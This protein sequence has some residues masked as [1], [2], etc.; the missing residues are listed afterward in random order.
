[1]KKRTLIEIIDSQ[2]FL[3]ELTD[4]IRTVVQEECDCKEGSVEATLLTSKEVL[5]KLKISAPTL[6]NQ[7][8]QGMIKHMKIGRGYR[9][10]LP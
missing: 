9:Y 4:Q 7:R 1:M 10:L 6:K 5:A 8:D 3:D 2:D